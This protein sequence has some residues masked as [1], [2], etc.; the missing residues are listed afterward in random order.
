MKECN[1][2]FSLSL[3][4][5]VMLSGQ[6]F[7][8]PI[9][10][11]E[12]AYFT[13]TDKYLVYDDPKTACDIFNGKV[14]FINNYLDKNEMPGRISNL[15]QH[16]SIRDGQIE[17]QFLI[18]SQNGAYGPWSFNRS[19]ITEQ[20]DVART[21]DIL[22]FSQS[23]KTNY[24]M[25]VDGSM[26]VTRQEL[27]HNDPYGASWTRTWD[28]EKVAPHFYYREGY[29]GQM[30]HGNSQFNFMSGESAYNTAKQ[31]AIQAAPNDSKEQARLTWLYLRNECEDDKT[32]ASC[33]PEKDFGRQ[34]V[35]KQSFPSSS[36]DKK[37][38]SIANST[39]FSFDITG[40]FEASKSDGP[41]AGLGVGFG[42]SQAEETSQTHTMMNFESVDEGND[43]GHSV[44]QTLNTSAVGS[45]GWYATYGDLF[46]DWHVKNA[47]EIWGSDIY[48]VYDLKS[49][50][51]WQENYTDDSNSCTDQKLVFGNAVTVSRAYLN[52][53]GSNW[54]INES[55]S[56]L[57]Q[58]DSNY[59]V[60]IDTQCTTDSNG[61]TYRTMKETIL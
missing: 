15:C 41:S 4:T 49:Y 22:M 58:K 52:T 12:D 9:P 38:I 13:G 59:G 40:S 11:I 28:D 42:F 34:F 21:I 44:V 51:S 37:E 16:A 56:K 5:V 7:A 60:V 36:N 53:Y 10:G 32:N 1:I 17:E 8:S 48:R 19:N 18:A 14:A 47:P 29:M 3:I 25:A 2:N 54:A 33:L 57:Y 23:D 6:A 20:I 26:N 43:I 61:Q 24:I 50:E 39:S 30:F 55:E 35:N 27:L 31:K 46:E 45:A